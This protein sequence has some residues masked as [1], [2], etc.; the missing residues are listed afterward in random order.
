MWHS[1]VLVGTEAGTLHVLRLDE[2]EK[3]E[4]LWEPLLE[5]EGGE[6]TPVRGCHQQVHCRYRASAQL[7]LQPC[8]DDGGLPCFAE[9][10]KPC[11]RTL[12]RGLRPEPWALHLRA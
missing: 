8:R 3:R 2:R 7:R 10:L 11:L 4:R 12:D 1:D 9:L 6:S 5:L